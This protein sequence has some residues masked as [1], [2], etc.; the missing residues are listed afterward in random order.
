MGEFDI[1]VLQDKDFCG[2]AFKLTGIV[3]IVFSVRTYHIQ[4]TCGI[5]AKNLLTIL[6]IGIVFE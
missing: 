6:Y 2:D 4:I 1:P 5:V 3:S